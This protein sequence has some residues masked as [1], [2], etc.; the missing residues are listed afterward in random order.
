MYGGV[1]YNPKGKAA[2]PDDAPISRAEM[3]D[4][5]TCCF[6]W[7]TGF[8]LVMALIL[9]QLPPSTDPL[10]GAH[11]PPASAEGLPGAHGYT[12]GDKESHPHAGVQTKDGGFLMVGDGVN[13]YA[14]PPYTVVRHMQVA[15][16]SSDGGLEW[17][18]VLGVCDYNYGKSG[19]ELAD[20]TYLVAG[21][22]CV[23]G[24]NGQPNVLKRAIVRVSSTGEVLYNQTFANYGESALRR[25]GIM[26][27]VELAGTGTV[28]A[29]GFVG[30][31]P[32][33]GPVA[34]DGSDKVRYHATYRTSE[35]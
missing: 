17:Q 11:V 10:Q 35:T 24:Q 18:L 22:I 15:K 5:V 23:K 1:D 34:T 4:E 21:A 14:D 19:I 26:S 28:V 32:K 2:K 7:G 8:L 16:T 13:Y 12:F 27:I 31:E 25:D 30:G 33:T 29:T 20:G 9:V 6:A 3:D